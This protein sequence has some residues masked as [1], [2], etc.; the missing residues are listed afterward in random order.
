MGDVD[1][2]GDGGSSL[3]ELMQYFSLTPVPVPLKKYRFVYGQVRE[4]TVDFYFILFTDGVRIRYKVL[5][6]FQG[7]NQ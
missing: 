1:E 4:R 2:N 5:F 3:E 6:C 7:S